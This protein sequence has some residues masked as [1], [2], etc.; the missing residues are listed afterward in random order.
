M[1]YLP[2]ELHCHTVHSDGAFQVNELLE[3]AKADHLALIALTDHNT[4]SG[5]AELDDSLLPAIKGIEWTTYFGHMLVLGAKEFVDWRDAVPNNIDEKIKAVKAAGGIVG[6]AHPFQMGSPICTGGRWEFNIKNWNNVDYM[7][8]WHEDLTSIK[9]ENKK[10]LALWTSLLDK[11]YKI[12]ASYGRDWHRPEKSGHYGCTYVD[13]DG[14]INAKHAIRAL[15][16]G[17]TV[18]STGAKFFFRVHR[19]GNTYS[20]GDTVRKGTYTFSFFTDLHSRMKNAGE[21]SVKYKTIKIVTNGG[22][23]VLETRFDERHVRLRLEKN[24][25]Y[26]AELWGTVD[27]ESNPLA[28]TSPLYCE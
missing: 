15:R 5:H 26:R 17:K 27:G 23:T 18:V 16:L 12:A 11:G 25:W 2:C 24:H 1:S 9:S 21:E 28:I 10:S 6:I 8:I 22:K 20:I 7:E 14:E 3:A 4:F 13:I 19:H